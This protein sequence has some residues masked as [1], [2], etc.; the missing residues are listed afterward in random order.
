MLDLANGF[1][2][3]SIELSVNEYSLRE[4]SYE[5]TQRGYA[6]NQ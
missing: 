5:V 6:G 4:P 1:Q 2:I 3:L